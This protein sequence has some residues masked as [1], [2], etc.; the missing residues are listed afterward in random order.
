MSLIFNQHKGNGPSNN[1]LD[2]FTPTSLQ[3]IF[4]LTHPPDLADKP[5]LQVNGQEQR[6]G[7]DYSI[8]GNNLNWISTDFI[9]SITDKID[10]Y[11]SY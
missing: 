1:E 3:T 2:F 8:V 9:L 11:Y 6:Y 4:V 7:I 10:I 5:I